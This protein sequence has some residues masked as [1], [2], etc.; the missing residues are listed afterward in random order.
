MLQARGA[1]QLERR[2]ADKDASAAAPHGRG[3]SARVRQ[4]LHRAAAAVEQPAA[5][6]AG[7]RQPQHLLA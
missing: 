2:A 6:A 3:E 7:S 5:V 4:R 1:G